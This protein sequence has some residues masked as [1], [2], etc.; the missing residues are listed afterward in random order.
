MWEKLSLS[1]CGMVRRRKSPCQVFL[2]K[3]YYRFCIPSC[4]LGYP[5]ILKVNFYFKVFEVCSSP[6]TWGNQFSLMKTIWILVQKIAKDKLFKI[7]AHI[8]NSP[9]ARKQASIKGSRKI[10]NW[11]LD[12]QY[13]DIKIIGHTIENTLHV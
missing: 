11:K 5:K 12:T 9:N 8:K 1:N 7:G 13:I 2:A 10:K 6:G 3:S 4:Y